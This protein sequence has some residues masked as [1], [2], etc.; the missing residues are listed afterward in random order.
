M[1]R[2]IR[3]LEDDIIA[4]LNASDVLIEAKRLVV[5]NIYNL[6]SKEADKAIIEESR[7]KKEENSDGIRE[8]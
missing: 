3:E 8:N 2:R 5:G 4:I 6:V 1:N 7:P